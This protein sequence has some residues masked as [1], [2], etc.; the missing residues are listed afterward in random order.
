MKH[1]RWWQP[2]PR[3]QA[4]DAL[5]AYSRFDRGFAVTLSDGPEVGFASLG[6]PD[7]G[8]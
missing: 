7:W 1:V 2:R 3:R 8:R 5:A 6:F 4:L